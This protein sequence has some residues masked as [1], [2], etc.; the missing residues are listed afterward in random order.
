MNKPKNKKKTQFSQPKPKSSLVVDV[1]N[2]SKGKMVFFCFSKIILTWLFLL[3]WMGICERACCCALLSQNQQTNSKKK[4]KQISFGNWCC[5]IRMRARALPQREDSY[6]FN[7]HKFSTKI[8]KSKRFVIFHLSL[9]LLMCVDLFGK[10]LSH[11]NSLSNLIEILWY[12]AYTAQRPAHTHNQLKWWIIIFE[13]HC[14]VTLVR[15]C[16]WCW[17]R[18]TTITAFGSTS[19]GRFACS[20][21]GERKKTHTH[22]RLCVWRKRKPNTTLSSLS[23]NFSFSVCVLRLFELLALTQRR[24]SIVRLYAVYNNQIR[25]QKIFYALF[26]FSA[27]HKIRIMQ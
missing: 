21:D 2:K 9:C 26:L 12:I 15:S 13:I 7:I 5:A 11:Y 27:S 6:K 1:S 23:H 25:I 14:H 16:C 24:V 10:H 20:F 8:S 19:S 17:Y 4:S 18:V 22:N 3:H